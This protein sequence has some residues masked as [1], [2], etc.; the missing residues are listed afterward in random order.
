MIFECVE[1]G[2]QFFGK[3]MTRRELKI[4]TRIN[5]MIGDMLFPHLEIVK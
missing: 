4:E 2:E 5:N 3:M 1:M